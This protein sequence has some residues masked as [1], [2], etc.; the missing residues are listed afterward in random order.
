MTEPLHALFTAVK[1]RATAVSETWAERVYMES[2]PAG[3]LYPYLVFFLSA[4]GEEN[5]IRAEDARYRIG[6]KVISDSYDACAI[7]S[8]RLGELFNDRGKHDGAAEVTATGWTI[9]NISREQSIF[10][11]EL[12]DGRPVYSMG[13]FYVFN[14]ET[15]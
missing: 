5:A 7:G 3:T 8:T 15:T 10:R 12:V 9:Q 14:M 6:M 4:G 2:A 11:K 13:A 1:T